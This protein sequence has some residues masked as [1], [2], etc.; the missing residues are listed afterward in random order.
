MVKRGW[1]VG[2][3]L[4]LLL[5]PAVVYGSPWT[6][7]ADDLVVSADFGAQN[8]SQEFL[9]DGTR[10]D[11]PLE[12]NHRTSSIS[13]TARYGF[14][15][16]LEGAL[17]LSISQV[18]YTANPLILNEELADREEAIDSIVNF[19]TIEF[20]A[21]DAYL[22]TNY[23]LF[24][25][26]GGLGRI[27][28]SLEGKLPTGYD[29]PTG[30]FFFDRDG[31]ERQGGQATLGDGQVDITPRI[32]AGVVI[33]QTSTFIRG[34][35]GFRYR[36]GAPGHQVTGGFRLGQM[37]GDHLIIMGGMNGDY[38]VRQGDV[39]GET[40]ITDDPSLTAAE[41]NLDNLI[42]EDLRLD[43]DRLNAEVGFLVD[44]GDVELTANYSRTIRGSNTGVVNAFN[45]G[46]ILTLPDVT[47]RGE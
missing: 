2:V 21:S 12:A 4:A 36:F 42:F 20:G 9:Q 41:F 44:L 33:P 24:S 39:I 35:A 28:A 3:V 43:R 7:P 5:S 8:A 1:S 45:V 10:Q 32:L 6:L 16:R 38:T 17:R 19:N 11:Y 31:T 14:T 26:L 47:N 23:R 27:T 46:T 25:P 40:V 22:R 13:I 15:D 29:D 34:D 37:L 18:G 30:T